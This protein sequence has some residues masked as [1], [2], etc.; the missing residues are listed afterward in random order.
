[1][2]NMDE[3]L[4]IVIQLYRSESDK[5]TKPPNIVIKISKKS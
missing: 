1:M 2:E 3:Y 5:W 4:K